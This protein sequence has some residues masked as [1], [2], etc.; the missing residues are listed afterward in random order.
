MYYNF[1]CNEFCTKSALQGCKSYS[2]MQICLEF[3]SR[4]EPTEIR[5]RVHISL[6]E[7]KFGWQRIF[8]SSL[9][10]I[11]I[12]QFYPWLQ[13]LSIIIV[14]TRLGVGYTFL[15]QKENLDGKDDNFGIY[16]HK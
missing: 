3:K 13:I 9:K 14:P 10:E 12:V 8:F 5:S 15:F 16:T 6:S 2:T 4:K 11:I 7:R 1:F